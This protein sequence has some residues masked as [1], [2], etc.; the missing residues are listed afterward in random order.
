[1]SS[2]GRRSPKSDPPADVDVL[3]EL[4]ARIWIITVPFL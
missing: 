4:W 2:S 3:P 1:M